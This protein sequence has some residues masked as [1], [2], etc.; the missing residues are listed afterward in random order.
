MPELPEVT[1][2][3]MGLRKAVLGKSILK[4]DFWPSRIFF[5][6]PAELKNAL[7]GASIKRIRRRGK[8][9]LFYLSSGFIMLVHLGMTGQLLLEEGSRDDRH[10]MM[11]LQFEGG[12]GLILRDPRRFGKLGLLQN[13]ADYPGLAAL[14]KDA[15]AGLGSGREILEVFKGSSLPLKNL[16]LDQSRISGVGNIYASEALFLSGLSPLRAGKTLKVKE[17]ELLRKALKSVLK[18]AVKAGGTT[19]D[20]TYVNS[21]GEAGEFLDH[22]RVYERQGEKCRRCGGTIRKITQS[23]RSTYFCPECQR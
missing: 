17:A 12:G 8:F 22:C 11:E 16:L 14:G 21:G 19:F 2:I 20:G 23:G 4:A 5:S 6:T 10:L 15:L 1:V 7:T 13:P 9:L 18:Q 3:A